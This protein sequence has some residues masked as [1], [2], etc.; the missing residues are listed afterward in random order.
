MIGI[1]QIMDKIATHLN[2]D[3]IALRQLNY[4]P[5]Y[6]AGT[7]CCTPYGQIVK[8]GLLGKIT[9]QLLET[10]DYQNRRQQIDTH[11]QTNPVLRRGLG[12]HQLNLESPLT[13]PC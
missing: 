7:P 2:M 12:L 11:N 4:Y 1:E 3:P 10:A 13:E 9:K 8:D 5:D 6:E